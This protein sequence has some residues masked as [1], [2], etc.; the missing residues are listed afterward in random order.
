M[1]ALLALGLCFALTFP[2]LAQEKEMKETDSVYITP[3][4]GSKIILVGKNMEKLLKENNLEVLKNKFIQDY[5]ESAKDKDFPA[6]AKN[7]IYLAGQDGRRRLKAVPDE[8]VPVKVE[9]EIESFKSNLPAYHYT[10]YDLTK[11]YEYHIYVKDPDDLDSLKSIDLTALIAGSKYPNR[12]LAFRYAKALEIV[13][14]DTGFY[15]K[16]IS[17]SHLDQLEIVPTV[18][19]GLINSSLSPNIGGDAYIHHFNKYGKS[20]F[21]TGFSYSFNM[22]AD[23]QNKK[24]S[25]FTPI[26]SYSLFFI[27]DLKVIGFGVSLGKYS[28]GK[29]FGSEQKNSL[30]KAWKFGII[31]DLKNFRLEYNFIFD[32]QKNTNTALTLRYYF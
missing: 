1:K 4:A 30:D 11:N 14:T 17:S 24:F 5:Q 12:F 19:L 2:L 8:T 18:G 15:F 21:K 25:N 23:Y 7:I 6:T 27:Q 28:S 13:P 31:S 9:D 22:L 32:K 29:I 3:F 10:I 16:N 20:S 26:S